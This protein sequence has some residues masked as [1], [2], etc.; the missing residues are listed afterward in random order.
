MQC[1][2]WPLSRLMQLK[3][4]NKSNCLW[5][6]Q[7][8]I[9]MSRYNEYFLMTIDDVIDY[10]LEKLPN[11]GWDKQSL[12][13]KEIGDGNLNYV[14]RVWDNQ[15][16]SVIVK[17]AGLTL[18]ISEDMKISTDRNRIE[19]E[20]LQLQERYAPGSVPKI[21][22]YDTV[23]S[24]CIMEDLSDHEM[25]RTAM[26]KHQTFPKFAEDITTFMVNTL[27]NTTDV[28]MEHKEKKELVKSFINP[29]LCE[30]TE[31]L[32]LL[33]P[34]NDVNKRN[35]VFEPN[36]NFVEKELY[37]DEKLHLEVAKLRFA[38][39][40]NAQALLH[41]DL[42]TGSIFI[43]P[44][45]TRVFDPEFAFFGPM[46]YDVGNII[47]NLV[48]A[49]D[50]G[51]ASDDKAFCDWCEKTIEEVIDL[52]KEKFIKAFDEKVTDLMAKTKGF[53]EAYLN[54][55][56]AD[57]AGFTGTELIRRTVGMAQVKDVTSIENEEKRALAE[58]INI[59]MGKNCIMN[60][61][62]FTTGAAYVK[63]LK[64]ALAQEA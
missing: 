57:T 55:I 59:I 54:S 60:R 58:R 38:F 16:N 13:T 47:A 15:G 53:K 40:N 17:H 11:Y 63:A 24:A 52:F 35:L 33:E 8:G 26:L 4:K 3:K 56:L 6:I 9:T 7:G 44:D 5:Q 46:G 21:Y 45:S 2:P 12:Q 42:H 30:I 19:S 61:E 18:R 51:H 49:W 22:M 10:V 39:M 31:D 64:Q 43:K 50:N 48:F 32:V 23:M 25:M 28:V 41:G 62:K 34:Y 20:I 36:K 29:E 37:Q 27:L 1:W 14:F